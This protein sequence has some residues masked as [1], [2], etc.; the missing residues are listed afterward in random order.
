M[1]WT[2]LGTVGGGMVSG[3]SYSEKE[4]YL[5][6][7]E[8]DPNAALAWRNLGWC[9][10]QHCSECTKIERFSAAAAAIFTAPP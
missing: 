9:G 5:R 4:C 2:N 3:T 1:A 10:T 6:A 7:L 8:I